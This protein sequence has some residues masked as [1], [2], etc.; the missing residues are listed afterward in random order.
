LDEPFAA[1][2]RWYSRKRGGEISALALL[3]LKPETP[4]LQL[5]EPGNPD[6]AGLLGEILPVLP[7][8]LFCHLSDGLVDILGRHY[9]VE[10]QNRVTKMRWK[11]AGN[12]GAFFSDDSRPVRLAPA[13]ERAMREFV[14]TP[15]F[16]PRMLK[17]GYYYGIFDGGELVSLAGTTVFSRKYGVAALGSVGTRES[18]RR[19]GLASHLITTM[20]L[21]LASQ[22]PYVGLNVRSDNEPAI[23]C[24]LKSGFEKHIDYW[25]CMVVK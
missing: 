15:W 3:Y 8:R 6:A 5:I 16:D 25:E 9:R 4:V 13:H 23:R 19:R 1:D 14:P 20:A 18:H 17:E 7:G 12:S 11:T 21:E 10:F 22:V 2:T 24:Y